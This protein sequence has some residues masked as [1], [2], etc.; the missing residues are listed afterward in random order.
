M[1]QT[2]KHKKEPSKTVPQDSRDRKRGGGRC[3]NLTS[4]KQK[5]ITD[6]PLHDRRNG[7]KSCP[8][9]DGTKCIRVDDY[10]LRGGARKKSAREET[11]KRQNQ[12]AAIRNRNRTMTRCALSM[13]LSKRNAKR[14]NNGKENARKSFA[15]RT[16]LTR[17]GRCMCGNKPIS[18]KRS[19]MKCNVRN[20]V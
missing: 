7:I 18:E 12:N 3:T 19:V 14:E 2:G 1:S 16:C 4:V 5:L 13:P 9:L 20:A 11:G 17:E 10:K 6:S 8:A 15:Y